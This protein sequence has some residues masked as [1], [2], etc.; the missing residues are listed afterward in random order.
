MRATR[1]LANARETQRQESFAALRLRRKPRPDTR[2]MYRASWRWIG[3]ALPSL[4][5]GGIF[6]DFLIHSAALCSASSSCSMVIVLLM[7][8]FVPAKLVTY[9]QVPHVGLYQVSR[10]CSAC[11][12][13]LRQCELRRG[14]SLFSG[15]L[16]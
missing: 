13:K 7:L 15:F 1:G 5:A 11:R 6:L 10:S 4:D 16:A 3:L 14:D 2:P 12:I 8:F 9:D